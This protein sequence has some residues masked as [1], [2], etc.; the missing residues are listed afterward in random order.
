MSTTELPRYIH[1]APPPFT[2]LCHH[3]CKAERPPPAALTSCRKPFVT[4]WRMM[5]PGEVLRCKGEHRSAQAWDGGAGEGVCVT[6]QG[7]VVRKTR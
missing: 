4:K 6:L 2:L 1:F 5:W 3:C 7:T